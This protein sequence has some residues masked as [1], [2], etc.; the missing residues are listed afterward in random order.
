MQSFLQAR[1]ED[2]RFHT[3][4]V[5][6]KVKIDFVYTA[7]FS[8]QLQ[9]ILDKSILGKLSMPSI[10]NLPILNNRQEKLLIVHNRQT[11]YL[12]LI[13]GIT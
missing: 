3:V 4:N 6:M 5:K 2:K 10:E 12:F 7:T 9:F 1:K 13:I 11:T 8:F